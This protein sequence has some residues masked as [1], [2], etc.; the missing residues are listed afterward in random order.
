MVLEHIVRPWTTLV[1]A[2]IKTPNQLND[3][4]SIY[5]IRSNDTNEERQQLITHQV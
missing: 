5:G 2:W 1:E 3:R 4:Y